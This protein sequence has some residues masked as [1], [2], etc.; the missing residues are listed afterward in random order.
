MKKVKS[1]KSWLLDLKQRNGSTSQ[2]SL[3]STD[4]QAGASKYSGKG[5]ELIGTD[6]DYSERS[7]MGGTETMSS[8]SPPLQGRIPAAAQSQAASTVPARLTQSQ[9][10]FG[11][12][13]GSLDGN[14]GRFAQS[15][16]NFTGESYAGGGGGGGQEQQRPTNPVDP[17]GVPEYAPQESHDIRSQ[18]STA[19]A[20]PNDGRV[21]NLSFGQQ[22]PSS[23]QRAAARYED[24]SGISDIE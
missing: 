18:A 10:N 9:G 4:E 22:Q 14:A 5:F 24:H 6:L 15:Q 2:D 20:A 1:V 8:S 11:I 16:G 23:P 12:M 19:R 13:Q 3:D 17:T 7:I 21:S